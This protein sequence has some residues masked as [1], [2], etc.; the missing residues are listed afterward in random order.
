MQP[1]PGTQDVLVQVQT[2]SPAG[3]ALGNPVMLDRTTLDY[4]GTP[5]PHGLDV[6]ALPDG[7]FA[8]FWTTSVDEPVY[9]R[10]LDDHVRGHTDIA[11]QMFAADGSAQGAR[12]AVGT[13]RTSNQNDVSATY[14]AALAQIV[15][16]RTDESGFTTGQDADDLRGA[17]LNVDPV[18]TAADEWHVLTDR[19]HDLN[20]LGGNDS[21]FGGD[22][23]D[24]LRGGAG[25]DLLRGGAGNDLI[26][27]GAGNDT[28]VP[29]AGN[30]DVYGGAGVDVVDF[31]G[32]G[33]G[34]TVALG[35]AG[36][37]ATAASQGADRFHSIEAV[38]G[39]A[40]DDRLFGGAGA[41][42]L[43]GGAGRDRIAG[44]GGNDTLDGGAG[45]GDAAHYYAAAGGVR[46]DLRA[47]GAVQAVGADQGDDLLSGFENILG[48]ATGDDTLQGD[49]GANRIA[50]YGGGD[51]IVGWGGDDLLFGGGGDDWLLG[52]DGDDL[53][54]GGV[55][56][57]T[58]LGGAGDDTLKGQD[59]PDWLDGGAG[60][61]RLEGGGM[62]DTLTGGADADL[63]VFRAAVHSRTGAGLRDVI[64][65]FTRGEDRV[66]LSAMDADTTLPGLQALVFVGSAGFSA[67]GQ[68]RFVTNGTD[69]FLLADVTGNGTADL[70]VMLQGTLALGAGDLIV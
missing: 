59:G 36:F 6:V 49:G 35:A 7:Q 63:F 8:V 16:T 24:T 20:A 19:A 33:E 26:G 47:Q 43:Q 60:A 51:V 45:D 9:V 5:L 15:V 14:N 29:G 31:S 69:G 55:G 11:G 34:V 66:D 67:A 44:G 64:R 57:D 68:L 38:I 41:E 42:R 46:V 50:G 30:D 1:V 58:V 54:E 61:D 22:G 48:S 52:S 13:T 39:S 10:Y 70:N 28:I 21:L 25:D 3:V 23:D 40:F 37:V 17:V 2:V 53:V 12:L 65:D 32:A 56:A 4:D 18:F 27:G 62:G